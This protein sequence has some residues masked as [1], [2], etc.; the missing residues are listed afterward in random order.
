MA[1]IKPIKPTRA[2][3]PAVADEDVPADAVAE[4]GE[5]EDRLTRGILQNHNES[6][7]TRGLVS[8]HNESRQTRGFESNHSQSLARR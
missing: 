3:R 8:N 7:Q 4:V 1:R 6:R 5:A 2:K